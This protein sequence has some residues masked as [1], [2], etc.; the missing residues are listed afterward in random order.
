MECARCHRPLRLIRSRPADKD[1]PRGRVFVASRKWPE[2]RICSGCYANAC[3]VYGTCAACRVHRLLPG[4]GEDGER[5]CTDCAGGLG[6]FTCTRCGNEGWN[7]YRGVCGRCVLSDRLTVQLD[8]GTGR[9]RPELVAFFDRIVAM[10]RPRVGILWLSKP[11]VPPI[12]HALAHG[13]IPLTH[14]GLSSLSPPKSVA[15]VRDL[16]IAAGVLPPADRQLVLFEQWLARWLEQLSDPAQH[17]IL[18]TYATWSV[19]RRLRKIAEDGPLGPYREQAARCGLRAAAAFLD[20]LA[21]HGVD[22]AGCRQ[23]DLDRWLATASDSAKKTLWP[24]FTWA[25]RTRRMP[26]LSLPPLRRET[27]KL[28]SLRERAELLRRIH[29]G[30]DMNLTERVIAMLILLYAQ[31]LSRI[32]R[33]SVDDITL[34]EHGEMLVRLGDPPAPVPAPFAAIIK[35]YLASRPNLTTA[36]NPNSTWLFPGQSAGQPLHPTSIRTRLHR[37][38]IPNLPG[39]S[40]ALRELVAHAPPSVVAGMLGYSVD[41]AAALAA[42]AGVTYHHYAAGDHART[43]SPRLEP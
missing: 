6:D 13:E 8:D 39:R 21:S 11:H 37:H 24:F 42:K 4:I 22:L 30:D 32:T 26:R 12:L 5:F 34:D 18:Q 41:K 27:P 15:H 40:R 14:D 3:E 10:D 16:L 38:G 35:D 25:I 7:H 29:V 33:L 31:P 28:I 1:D 36:A 17:K 23:A 19:L 2:G 20:E 9:V 43:R